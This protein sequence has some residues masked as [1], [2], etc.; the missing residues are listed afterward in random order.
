MTQKKDFPPIRFSPPIEVVTSP[1]TDKKATLRIESIRKKPDQ[2]TGKNTPACIN[3]EI[4]GTLLWEEGA[5]ERQSLPVNT[6]VC[7]SR[8]SAFVLWEGASYSSLREAV[9]NQISPTKN[10]FKLLKQGDTV[11]VLLRGRAIAEISN[12]ILKEFIPRKFP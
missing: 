2:N 5:N 8:E 1:S 3:M 6:V 11:L 4:A 10:Q 7:F 9:L 12:G